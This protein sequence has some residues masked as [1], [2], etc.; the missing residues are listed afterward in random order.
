MGIIVILMIF[1]IVSGI[2]G[3]G[4]KLGFGWSIMVVV[5]LGLRFKGVYY[6]KF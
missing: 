5:L 1:R 3:K 6:L 2:V 4:G